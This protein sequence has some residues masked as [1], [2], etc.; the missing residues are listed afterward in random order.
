MA[1]YADSEAKP[2]IHL[3]DGGL[4]D[5][6]GV[7]P[8]INRLSMAGNSWE[9]AK[10]MGAADTHRMLVIVVNAQSELS[11]D[12]QKSDVNLSLFDAINASSSI[13]LNQYSFES[14]TL[15]RLAFEGLGAQLVKGRCKEWTETR[16]S[17]QGC[18]DFKVY[19]VEVELIRRKATRSRSK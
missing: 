9:L 2:Y 6:L 8:F 14:L 3:Y 16:Q 12:F 4:S 13:P 5:N 18:D 11:D 10:A 7:R 19:L 15:L 1:K 17:A